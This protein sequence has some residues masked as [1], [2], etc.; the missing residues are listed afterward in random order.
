[1]LKYPNQITRRTSKQVLFDTKYKLKYNFPEYISVHFLITLED[2][3]KAEEKW[4][5]LVINTL[6]QREQGI[7]KY[8]T[9]FIPES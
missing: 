3:I 4:K 7:L 5:D 6:E 9:L 1:M 2:I 8:G